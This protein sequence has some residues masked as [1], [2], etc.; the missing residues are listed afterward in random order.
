[1]RYTMNS[2]KEQLLTKIHSGKQ[3]QFLRSAASVAK[4]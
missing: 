1:M 4:Q 3:I 2:M